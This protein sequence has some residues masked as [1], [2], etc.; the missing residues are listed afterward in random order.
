MADVESESETPTLSPELLELAEQVKRKSR[1][2]IIRDGDLVKYPQIAG[3]V[4]DYLK[5]EKKKAKLETIEEPYRSNEVR[6]ESGSSPTPEFQRE[7]LT[8]LTETQDK[9]LKESIEKMKQAY[10]HKLAASGKAVIKIF[11]MKD[12]NDDVW[13]ELNCNYRD[14][15]MGET[16]VLRLMKAKEVDLR[17]QLD[18]YDAVRGRNEPKYNEIMTEV[19][20]S[21]YNWQQ[22]MIE[23]YWGV[24]G[25][26]FDLLHS[27]D[28]NIAIEV[29]MYREENIYPNF[30][31][32][33]D[34]FFSK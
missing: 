15:M 19:S 17:R 6:V 5:G 12:G 1:A 14:L 23:Y 21:V 7:A 26:D 24:K 22:K 11:G 34:D 16:R 13:F 28:V 20:N 25:L 8:E 30:R 10:V 2:E 18:Y 27:Q 32:R 29:A 31:K 4:N 9:L 33:S 3:I